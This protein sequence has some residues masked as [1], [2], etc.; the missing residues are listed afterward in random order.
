M[1][2]RRR[3]VA[4]RCALAFWGL[5]RRTAFGSVRELMPYGS[6]V[7]E[8]N[9]S[10]MFSWTAAPRDLFVGVQVQRNCVSGRVSAGV[11]YY[12]TS[13]PCRLRLLGHTEL[14]ICR[15]G[16]ISQIEYTLSHVYHSTPWNARLEPMR[17]TAC[18]LRP[19]LVAHT[20][21]QQLGSS[22]HFPF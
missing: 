1:R 19:V 3:F 9:G 22:M 17:P 4:P 8:I 18:Q 16:R 20:C 14:H 6:W 11:L 5:G 10:T 2:R 13:T 21:G 15:H 7:S 12:S